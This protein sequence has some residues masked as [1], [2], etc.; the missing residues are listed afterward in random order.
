LDDPK[1]PLKKPELEEECD[2]DCDEPNDELPSA[3][4]LNLYS[5]K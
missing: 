1:P 3:L 4:W 5:G 2:E